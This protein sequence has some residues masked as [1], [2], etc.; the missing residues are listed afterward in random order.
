MYQSQAKTSV[1][2]NVIKYHILENDRKLLYAEVI[3]KWKHDVEFRS[4]YTHVLATAEFKA[5][6][7]EHPPITKATFE[8]TYE[9]ILY[10]SPLLTKVR[11]DRHSFEKYFS[12]PTQYEGI[13]SFMNLGKNALLVVPCPMREVVE[14]YTHLAVFIREA[15]EAQKHHLWQMVAESVENQLNDRPTW[16]STA[17]LGV[18]WLHIR[19]DTIPKY[20]HFKPYKEVIC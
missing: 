2:G 18:Y 10:D 20:Y 6:F 4:F 8:Q 9:F 15:P 7:W 12:Q 11:T 16:L 19:L 3:Q 14:T 13:V 17:G 5:F 1:S